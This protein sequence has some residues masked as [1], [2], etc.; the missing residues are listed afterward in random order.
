M[1]PAVLCEQ[2]EDSVLRNVDI[3]AYE[4][5]GLSRRWTDLRQAV[6]DEYSHMY[7]TVWNV[8]DLS[9]YMDAPEGVR[10]KLVNR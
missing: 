10:K 7:R 5:I 4:Y 8:T 6:H 2:M 1:R 3:F 9:K